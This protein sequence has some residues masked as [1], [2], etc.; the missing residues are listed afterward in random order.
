MSQNKTKLL[1][2]SIFTIVF[3]TVIKAQ[4]KKTQPPAAPSTTAAATTPKTGPK[5]YTEVITDKA[6]SFTG[7]FTAHKV[8]D[9]WYFEI[10]DSVLGREVL[11]ITRV[12]KT[13][14]GAG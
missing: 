10:P 4:D 1:L 2:L 6:K 9:K 14:T 5:P 11:A 7:L 13:T 3:L 8:E 12:S